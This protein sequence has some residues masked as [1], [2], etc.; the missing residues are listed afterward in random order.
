MIGDVY[1][2]LAIPGKCAV[3]HSDGRVEI[4][5]K[6]E[7]MAKGAG[8][9]AGEGQFVPD[10]FQSLQPRVDQL[11]KALVLVVRRIDSEF[12]LVAERLPER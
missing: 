2:A 8:L 3:Q 12:E 7:P 1:F 5:S 11:E 6:G 10:E 9:D 4:L